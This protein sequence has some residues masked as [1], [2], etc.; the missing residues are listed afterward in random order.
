MRQ[1]L[2][3]AAFAACSAYAQ[4]PSTAVSPAHLQH[5]TSLSVPYR[6]C[7]QDTLGERYVGT[8]VRDPLQL[9]ADVERSCESKLVT[10]TRYL[11]EMGYTAPVVRQ[12]VVELKAMADGAA[13]AYVHR[14]PRY[15]F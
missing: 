2:A 4:T 9:A 7:L 14:L 6:E 12:T 8:D 1:L 11:G 15:R 3:L 5:A 13:I 10:V